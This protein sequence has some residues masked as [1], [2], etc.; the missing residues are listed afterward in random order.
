LLAHSEWG[1]SCNGIHATGLAYAYYGFSDAAFQQLE[2]VMAEWRDDSI[3]F[4]FR[5]LFI[6]HMRAVR[7]DSRFMPLAARLGLVDYWLE[8]GQWPDFCHDEKLPY[9]CKEAAL[10]ARANAV[11]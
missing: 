5:Y 4:E 1:L 9:D 3:P 7:T 6:P 11:K 10:A 2:A 8:S